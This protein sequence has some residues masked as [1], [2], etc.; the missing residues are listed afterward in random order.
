[1]VFAASVLAVALFT[2]IPDRF[3]W[4]YG[5]AM[6]PT[7][8]PVYW[9]PAEETLPRPELEALQ[10]ARLKETVGRVCERVPFYRKKFEQAKVAL[11][12]HL[13]KE[14]RL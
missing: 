14:S 7:S 10:L 3:F 12:Q 4:Q 2:R 11:S 6:Q 8:E 1:M 13:T 9:K 5:A